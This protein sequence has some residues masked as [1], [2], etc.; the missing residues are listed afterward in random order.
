ML[1][2]I[3]DSGSSITKW[4]LKKGGRKPSE[5]QVLPDF[6]ILNTGFHTV[7]KNTSE[8]LTASIMRAT[9]CPGAAGSKHH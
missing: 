5:F 2:A 6:G 4:R 7:N 8:E 3:F 1:A 9:Y